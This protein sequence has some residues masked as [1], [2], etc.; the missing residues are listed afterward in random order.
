MPDVVDTQG[1]RVS[2][3][4]EIGRGGEAV[5]FEVASDDTK[6]AKI[7]HAPLTRERADKIRLMPSLRSE[8]ISKLA[9]W[10]IDL[11]SKQSGEPIGL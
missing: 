9:A 7:F 6:L 10:P 8:A 3:G 11:L 4:R 5:V 2:L 1:R